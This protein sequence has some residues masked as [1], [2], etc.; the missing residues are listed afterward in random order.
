MSIRVV[1]VTASNLRR[2]GLAPDQVCYVGRGGRFHKWPA[3]RWANPFRGS[4]DGHGWQVDAMAAFQRYAMGQT[5]DWWL[6][7]WKACERGAKPLGCWCADWDGETQPAP[8]CHAVTLA[9]E[10]HKRFVEGK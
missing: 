9:A 4:K 3:S 8:A 7:L 5:P 6:D 1:N 10:L 2:L